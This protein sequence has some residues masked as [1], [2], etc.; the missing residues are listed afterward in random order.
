LQCLEQDFKY[1]TANILHVDASIVRMLW[2]M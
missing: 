2:P 1:T